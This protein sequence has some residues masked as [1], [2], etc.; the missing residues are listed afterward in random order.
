MAAMSLGKAEERIAI[1]KTQTIEEIQL[2]IAEIIEMQ[3]NLMRFAVQI[4]F[5]IQKSGYCVH[6]K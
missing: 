2:K 3:L 1:R 6:L 4:G 5:F